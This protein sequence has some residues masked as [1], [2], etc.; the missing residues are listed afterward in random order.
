MTATS[1]GPS[2]RTRFFV[3]RSSLAAPVNSTKR[4]LVTLHGGQEL[5]AAEHTLDL[6]APLRL[7][8]RF[9]PR[10]SGIAGQLLYAEVAVGAAGDLRQRSEERRVGKEC[11]WEWS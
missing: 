4:P 10:V 6:L 1:S 2:R 8:E 9:D 7:H 11:R 5:P 3:R